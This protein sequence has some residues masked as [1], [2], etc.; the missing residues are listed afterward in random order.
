MRIGTEAVPVVI[1]DGFSSDPA[2]LVAAACAARFEPAAAH[3]PGIRAP[4]PPGYFA[5][6]G[7]TIAA[8]FGEA[9]GFVRSA[10]IIDAS[11]AMVTRAPA[12]LSLEQRV[13]HI[14]AHDPGRIAMVHFLG[15]SDQGGTA[16]FRHR[17][18]G[19][20]TIDH[21][22]SDRYLALLSAE[23]RTQPPPFAYVRDTTPLF[24]RTA[25]IKPRVNRALFYPSALLHSGAIAP[26]APLAADPATG[27]LTI[28][29][30]FNAE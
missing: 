1:V 24:E 4:L 2:A 27:R 28:T 12:S 22:R 9:F 11:F 21:D 26:D 7:T 15:E 8:I 10:R 23:L 19:F 13:P 30:F 20:E 6:V 17:A 25:L 14:D 3:Y 16:F 5:S 29:A 18:T